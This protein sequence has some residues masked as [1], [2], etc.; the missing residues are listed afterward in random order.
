M[1]QRRVAIADAQPEDRALLRACLERLGHRVLVD[2]PGGDELFERCRS[3]DP[4]LIVAD[5]S[6]RTRDGAS[7][8]LRTAAQH[9]L[10]VVATSSGGDAR[11]IGQTPPQAV[12]AYLVKPI[13]EAELAAVI[14]I[15]ARRHAE[16]ALLKHDADNARQLLVDRK[17]IE[18]AKGLIMRR[19]RIDEPEAFS[20][21]RLAARQRRQKIVDVA[22]SILR[23][24]GV[25]SD[26]PPMSP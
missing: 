15:A 3:S 23:A 8:A 18:R 25:I 6:L 11:A 9:G 2:A 20:Q 26:D 7:A 4:E 10:P 14:G 5:L 22:K 13:R 17:I 21:L 1:D 24:E 19:H 12:Y 16:M